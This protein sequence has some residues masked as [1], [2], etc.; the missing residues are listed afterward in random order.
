[1]QARSEII[2]EDGSILTRQVEHRRDAESHCFELSVGTLQVGKGHDSNMP[3][4][5]HKAATDPAWY[6]LSIPKAHGA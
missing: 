2:A 3:E 4:A 1:M 6:L 5:Y